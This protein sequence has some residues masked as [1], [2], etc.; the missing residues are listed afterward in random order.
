MVGWPGLVR[1]NQ[2]VSALPMSGFGPSQGVSPLPSFGRDGFQFGGR[3]GITIPGASP[4]APAPTVTSPS[5][6]APAAPAVAPQLQ[7]PA[8]QSPAPAPQLS[9]PDPQSLLNGLPG[10]LSALPQMLTSL[11]PPPPPPVPAP[12][13]PPPVAPPPPPPP[14]AAP[15]LPTPSAS[16]APAA[17]SAATPPTTDT[18]P[19][20]TTTSP[21]ATTT[22]PPGLTTEPPCETT[23]PP[24]E[25]TLPPMTSTLPPCET[26]LPPMTTTQPPSQTTLPPWLTGTTPLPALPPLPPPSTTPPASTTPPQPAPL[27]PLQPLAPPTKPAGDWQIFGDPVIK[28]LGGPAETLNNV[29][30]RYV[31]MESA[32]GDYLVE[33][34]IVEEQGTSDVRRDGRNGAYTQAVAVRQGQDLISYRNQRNAKDPGGVVNQLEINGQKYSLQDLAARGTIPLPGGGEVRWSPPYDKCKEGVITVVSARGD[35]LVIKDRGNHIDLYGT[36]AANRASGTLAGIAGANDSRG[37]GFYKRSG[38]T[39]GKVGWTGLDPIPTG[40]TRG[41]QVDR[42][43]VDSWKATGD[44]DLLAKG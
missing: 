2:G 35:Q 24:C 27:P 20:L 31:A 14:V 7:A 36:P 9:L 44:E 8:P 10:L 40:T 33:Q 1:G 11:V 3:L 17:P 25:T 41:V 34:E 39:A 28:E 22:Q 38:Q 37:P 15:S 16:P 4:T 43:Y 21:P 32:E 19:A 12:P 18:T 29:G 5:T 26:T 30:G 13:P 42:G 23:L 6:V